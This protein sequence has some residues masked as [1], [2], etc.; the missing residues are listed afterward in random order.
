LGDAVGGFG[1]LQHQL[2][3]QGGEIALGGGGLAEL[4][5]HAEF[6]PELGENLD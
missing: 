2:M 3:L 4:Q 5:E 1:N 6:V